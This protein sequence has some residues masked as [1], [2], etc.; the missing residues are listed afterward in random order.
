MEIVL[1]KVDF[2]Y[3]PKNLVLHQIDLTLNEPGL[4]CII[5]PNGVGKSTLI[6]CINKLV[7]PTSGE[8]YIDGKSVKDYT[9]K[10]LAR[11]MGY[12]PVK[13]QDCFAMNVIDT[14]L[15]GRHNQNKWK[16]TDEDLEAVHKVMEMMNLSDLAMRSFNELSAGQHQKVAIARGLV[17]NPQVLILD[18]PTS[19]LDVR[20]QIQ[21]TQLLRAIAESN[22]MTIIMISHDL[23]IAAKYAHKVVVM[24]P[25]GVI[26]RVGTP[27]EVITEDVVRH[28]YGVNCEVVRDEGRP[29]VIL[30]TEIPNEF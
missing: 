15:I 20:H 1:D 22:D 3:D 2:G 13:T 10:D 26:Y 7:T 5:G 21:V 18:E 11:F 29:H 24:A 6:R 28:V 9:L 30:K 25:P 8:V 14:I 17:Q 19:N 4:V 12:V 16:T 27:D 23:N